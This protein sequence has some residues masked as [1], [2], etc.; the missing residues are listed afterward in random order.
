MSGDDASV[1][2]T[3]F[4]KLDTA[5]FQYYQCRNDGLALIEG[6][7]TIRFNSMHVDPASL[8]KKTVQEE[9]KAVLAVS[10]C[11]K[12][13]KDGQDCGKSGKYIIDAP[14]LT[15]KTDPESEIAYSSEL[16]YGGAKDP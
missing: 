9:T 3:L 16:T 14:A 6:S 13:D 11:F 4:C 10:V 15:V 1:V 7:Y 2:Q 5:R 8:G 12:D